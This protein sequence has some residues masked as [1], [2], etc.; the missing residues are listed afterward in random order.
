[1]LEAIPKSWFSWN[2]KIS[3]DSKKIADL[4]LSSWREKGE[5]RIDGV[6]YV[7]RRK[8]FLSSTILLELNNMELAKASK[9]SVF[10][11]SFSLEIEGKQYTVKKK[12]MLGRAII[13]TNDLGEIGSVSPRS[14]LSRRA[15][16]DLPEEIDLPIRM[17]IIWLAL[18]LWKHESETAAGGSG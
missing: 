11:R 9:S 16:V 13:L 17:F 6:I 18:L 15:N 10:R 1:M 5:L 12:S 2:F 14:F 3:D 7:V 8:G 4:E